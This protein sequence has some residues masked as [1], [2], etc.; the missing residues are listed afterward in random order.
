MPRIRSALRQAE[1]TLRW[2]LLDECQRTFVVR[3]LRDR[4]IWR[5][6]RATPVVIG[7]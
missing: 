6:A 2:M 4:R 5:V 7:A 1:F 3:W